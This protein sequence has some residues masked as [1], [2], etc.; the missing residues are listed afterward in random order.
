MVSFVSLKANCHVYVK[1][2][3]EVFLKYSWKPQMHAEM[4]KRQDL[5]ASSLTSVSEGIGEH[6]LRQCE[7]DV[8]GFNGAAPS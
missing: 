6:C 8:D 4:S 3:G 7:S 5:G 2:Q 1:G